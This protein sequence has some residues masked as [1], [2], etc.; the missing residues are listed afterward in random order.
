[1]TT[2]YTSILKLA[3]PVQGEL[4]GSW[5]DVV[6][7]NITEMVEEAI[8][9]RATI[10][11]WAT[12]SH[13]LTEADGTTSE[14]RAAMLNL[15]DT[16]VALSGAGTLIC[17]TATKIYIVENGTGQQITVKT[18]AGS[19]V[20]IP[21][22]A[23]MFVFCDGTDVV[24]AVTNIASLTVD[25]NALTISNAFTTSGGHAV[26][27][28]T[29]GTTDVTLPA[30]GT[31]ATVAQV[32]T[33]SGQVQVSSNDTT[34]GD[35]ET[36]LLVGTGLSLATQNEGGNETRTVSLDDT[37]IEVDATGLGIGD[38]STST[39]DT[40]LHIKKPVLIVRLEDTDG[41]GAYS[42]IVTDA[43]G[44][45][46]FKADPLNANPTGGVIMDQIDGSY[47]TRLN[48]TGLLL[49]DAAASSSASTALHVKDSSPIITMEDTD[50]VSTEAAQV[51]T[52]VNGRLYLAADISNVNTSS[53]IRMLDDNQII[54]R[55]RTQSQPGMA[56]FN[57]D[58]R[59]YIGGDRVRSE[60]A[61]TQGS[62]ST[63]FNNNTTTS[64]PFPFNFSHTWQRT[65]GSSELEVECFCDWEV[66]SNSAGDAL[67][68][69][70]LYY[71]TGSGYQ[72][73][74]AGGLPTAICEAI[75]GFRNASST[76]H[77]VRG[78][79]SF[80]LRLGNATYE[81]TDVPITTLRFGGALIDSGATFGVR[82]MHMIMREVLI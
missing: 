40:A 57:D 70:E 78:R 52:D 19:G 81:R 11:S 64:I 29:T 55:L 54:G 23:T 26:T 77:E 68:E 13:T 71:Y 76:T 20:A 48:T 25:G 62:S 80:K 12:N 31:L 4:D 42:D 56:L 74:S 34:P 50:R 27:L 82:A 36:K 30:T 61:I 47:M 69:I 18:S 45:L 22:G 60:I 28:T 51:F 58:Y 3:L 67:A 15:T 46:Y 16:G 39:P 75:V 1:M 35:I 72:K 59:Y 79:A 44:S 49:G 73:V 43:N 38:F 21:D 32:T 5:G 10:N 8:A 6:N 7:D 37:L 63:L 41:G 33:A 14:S 66:G 9:G 65:D 17:P 2:A 24:Q 53:E